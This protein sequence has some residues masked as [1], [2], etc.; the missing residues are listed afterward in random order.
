[1]FCDEPGQDIVCAVNICDAKES[2]LTG[3]SVLH[4]VPQ[5]FYV[6]F[7]LGSEREDLAYAQ[8]FQPLP[9]VAQRPLLSIEIG[10]AHV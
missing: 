10:R 3:Q 9:E 7:R 1:M 5:T 4:G 6:S 2:Q 8:F